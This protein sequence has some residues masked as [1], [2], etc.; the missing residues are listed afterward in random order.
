MAHVDVPSP[1]MLFPGSHRVSI[2][3]MDKS[4]VVPLSDKKKLTVVH[5]VSCWLPLTEIWLYNQVKFLPPSIESLVV[6]AETENLDHF[7][8]QN[9]YSLAKAPPLRRFWDKGLRK[10]G[11][12]RHL[13]LLVV[14]AKRNRAHVLHS[15]FGNVGWIN[16]KAAGEAGLKHFV[17]F[18]GLD[19][20]HLPKRNPSWRTRYRELFKK[21]D[22]VLCEGPYM[23]KRIIELGCSE[24]KIA[25]HHLGVNVSEILFKPRVWDYEQPLRVFI[26]ASFREKKGIP[27][28]IEALARLHREVSL[29]IT[30]IGD[31][32][33][34][35]SSQNEKQK[36]LSTIDKH[37]LQSKVRMLG[38]QPHYR[39][40][41]EA[42]KHHIFLSPSL[43]ASDG[44][45]EGGAPATITEMAA[46]GM[47]VVSTNHCD[48]PEIVRN[49]LTGLLAEEKDVDGLVQHLEWL[50]G[51]P[52]KWE[53]MAEA[54]RRHIE[55]EFDAQ[56]QGEKL[57]SIYTGL[58]GVSLE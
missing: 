14:Q 49:G 32:N 53:V 22:R 51:N 25:V 47:P 7:P 52:D 43:T 50:I 26:V 58:H 16:I 39:V 35:K 4:T 5:S 56:T 48:I 54:G 21:A 13:G 46:T 20:G 28:A 33:H 29:E 55:A 36:I 17:T 11:I 2:M 45:I 38:Y 18:Y 41:E 42:Y 23:A 6:C 3:D 10:L 19:V 31:A 30:I 27:C 1:G 37:N 24:D 40:L 8:I 15:H 44:D 34:T 9:I 12:R 57:A